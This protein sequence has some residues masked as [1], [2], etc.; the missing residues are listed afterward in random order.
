MTGHHEIRVF[1]PK[2]YDDI[3]GGQID[4]QLPDNWKPFAA[5]YDT[6]LSQWMVLARRWVRSGT[7]PSGKHP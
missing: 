1:Y 2:F 3:L 4:Y 7:S 6:R 5:Y